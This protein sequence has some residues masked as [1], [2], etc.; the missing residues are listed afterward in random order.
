VVEENNVSSLQQHLEVGNAAA[1]EKALKLK[2]TVG[3]PYSEYEYYSHDW[4]SELEHYNFVDYGKTAS[5]VSGRYR[6]IHG[7]TS[8]D[9]TI[10]LYNGRYYVQVE[11]DWE[12]G[13]GTSYN[14]NSFP[15]YLSALKYAYGVVFN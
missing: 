10:I 3:F 12:Y 8:Y 7:E 1:I 14:C 2:A 4:D 6:D 13:G 5:S 9:T 15:D 11:K